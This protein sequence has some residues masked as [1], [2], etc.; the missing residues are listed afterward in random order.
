MKTGFDADGTPV[1]RRVKVMAIHAV[2][3]RIQGWAVLACEYRTKAMSSKEVFFTADRLKA[4]KQAQA[5]ARA[6]YRDLRN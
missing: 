6:W 1:T 5:Y 4:M 2:N 3:G